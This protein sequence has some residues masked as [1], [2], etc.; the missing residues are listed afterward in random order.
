M[1]LDE[2]KGK[3]KEEEMKE[4]LQKISKDSLK[5]NSL[6]NKGFFLFIINY[7]KLINNF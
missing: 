7:E 2:N 1:N 5:L 3:A 6:I 4:I